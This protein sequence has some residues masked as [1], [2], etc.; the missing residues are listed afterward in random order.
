MDFAQFQILHDENGTDGQRER[1]APVAP[2]HATPIAAAAEVPFC[3]SPVT[4]FRTAAKETAVR[5]ERKKE[6]KPRVCAS[7]EFS[8]ARLQGTRRGR[9][10]RRE[11]R[12]QGPQLNHSSFAH[13]R[14]ALHSNG[15]LLRTLSWFLRVPVSAMVSGGGGRGSVSPPKGPLWDRREDVT[16]E[17]EKRAV[18]HGPLRVPGRGLKL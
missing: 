3:Y 1:R 16:G 9:P 4:P 7:S 8:K 14:E 18:R 5:E 17:G 15:R 11:G 10:A 6:R 13:F 12:G 2:E